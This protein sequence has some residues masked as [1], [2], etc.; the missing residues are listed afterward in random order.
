MEVNSIEA[1]NVLS[2]TSFR[3]IRVEIN[4]SKGRGFEA[5]GTE[6]NIDLEIVEKKLK[7][8]EGGSF[9]QEEF[10]K[11]LE[12]LFDTDARPE[13]KKVV[14][15]ASFAFKNA[16]GHSYGKEFPLPMATVIGKAEGDERSFQEFVVFP[17]NP[18]SFSEALTTV[19][20]VYNEF[21]NR[22][23]RKIRG[24]NKK[25]DLITSMDD[26]KILKALK[27]SSEDY[28]VR[29]GLNVSGENLN[30]GGRYLN[31]S[32]GIEENEEG[33]FKVLDSLID[34]FG[35]AYIEDPFKAEGFHK[36]SK[37]TRKNPDIAVSGSE[38]FSGS[39]ERFKSG[40][41][42]HACNSITIKGRKSKNVTEMVEKIDLAEKN[43]YSIIFDCA[44]MHGFENSISK[45]ALEYEI[46]FVKFSFSELGID[47]MN[48][49]N[50]LWSRI[51]EPE[52]QK[53][54]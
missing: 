38:I 29:I 40:I 16:S 49:L 46:S 12:K 41:E 21:R 13:Y 18:E 19:L 7:Q 45:I 3:D 47:Q 31:S 15:A 1:I 33:F 54:H 6:K 43:D 23:K 51:E 10:D 22:Y 28:D 48:Q 9:S 37:L 42:N 14:Q 34:R 53:D 2:P 35:L 20:D 25:G 27:K 30:E 11:R 36:Y 52:I 50:D 32:I 26:E 39:S 17:T 44:G 4:S 8:L 24:R 5:E